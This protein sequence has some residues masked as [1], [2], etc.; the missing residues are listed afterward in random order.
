MILTFAADVEAELYVFLLL[1]YTQGCDWG[2]DR[3]VE[4]T[5]GRMTTR[6]DRYF[7]AP[8]TG[9]TVTD[10]MPHSDCTLNTKQ[11]YWTARIVQ[12]AQH[13]R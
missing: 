8:S 2:K 6:T 1:T 13:A 5:K 10:S 3:K 7:T 9:V 4:P 11:A 12:G